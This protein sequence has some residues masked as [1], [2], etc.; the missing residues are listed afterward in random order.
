MST[1][2][3]TKGQRGFT[4]VEMVATITIMALIMVPL[5][6]TMIQ[7]MTA[8]PAAGDRSN[9]ATQSELL[10]TY[11]SRDVAQSQLAAD[12]RSTLPLGIEFNETIGWYTQSA[13][14]NVSCPATAPAPGSS[15]SASPYNPMLR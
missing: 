14:T 5:C 9:N 11:F 4:L 7:A 8:V 13:T 2:R 1:T 3:V 12:A 15:G 10:A 6:T